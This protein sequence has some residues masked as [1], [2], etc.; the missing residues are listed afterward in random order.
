MKLDLN[1]IQKTQKTTISELLIDGKFECYIL[2]DYDRCLTQH[3]P[4]DQIKTIKVYGKTC[5]PAGTYDVVISWSNR[6]NKYLP[7]LINVPGFE[8]I[9]IHPGNKEEDSLGCLLPGVTHSP[10]FVGASKIAFNALFSKLKAV[11]KNEKITIKIS[12]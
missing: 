5:I 11:E 3:T 10:D 9:R 12:R 1:P 7:L 6:F 2:E 4:I 8:G